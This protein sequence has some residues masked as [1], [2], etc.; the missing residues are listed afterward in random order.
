MSFINIVHEKIIVFYPDPVPKIHNR[1]VERVKSQIFKKVK[2]SENGV[3]D[4]KIEGYS[5]HFLSDNTKTTGAFL[6]TI[7]ENYPTRFAN[8]L[9]S[10]LV[11]LVLTNG[12][13]KNDTNYGLQNQ[14]KLD[15]AQIFNKFDKVVETDGVT[16]VKIKT[17]YAKAKVDQSLQEVFKSVGNVK[18]LQE[19]SVKLADKSQGML[20]STKKLSSFYTNRRLFAILGITLGSVAVVGTVVGLAIYFRKKA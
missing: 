3:R 4:I 20:E 9:L 11:K 14:L 16:I 6:I 13:K 2:N 8:S 15:L 7:G 1:T 18:L 19:S 17:D 10:E 12:Y 5:L